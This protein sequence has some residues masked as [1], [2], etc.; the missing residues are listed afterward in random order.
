GKCRIQLIEIAWT[1]GVQQDVR[2]I[3]GDFCFTHAF[4]HARIRRIP[5]NRNAG[6]YRRQRVKDIETFSAQVRRHQRVAG[7][8]S[9]GPGKGGHQTHSDWIAH[10]AKND[11][12]CAGSFLSGKPRWRPSRYNDVDLLVHQVCRKARQ[13]FDVSS[14]RLA[15]DDDVL[16]LHITELHELAHEGHGEVR[17]EA[18]IEEP[19]FEKLL[20]GAPDRQQITRTA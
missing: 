8:I 13:E 18:G 6:N 5:E 4:R 1:D 20:C 11:W 7:Y 10:G 3:G 2:L 9:S 12:D 19:N 15:L 17:A 16:S 14:R